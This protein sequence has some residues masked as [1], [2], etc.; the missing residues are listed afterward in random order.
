MAKKQKRNKTASKNIILFIFAVLLVAAISFGIIVLIKQMQ[1]DKSEKNDTRDKNTA[2]NELKEEDLNNEDKVA[3]A[4]NNTKDRMEADE[5][6]KADTTVDRDESGKK[7]AKPEISFLQLDGDKVAVGGAIYNLNET[8]GEC[9]YSF[10]KSGANLEFR[11]DVLPNPSYISCSTMQIDKTKFTTGVWSV[12][13]KYKSN[14][15]EGES[16]AKSITIQ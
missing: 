3:E 1:A 14:T 16:E 2:S 9:L 12:K 13:I 10:T 5:Q 15:A 8:G 11:A 6:A 7:I 4:S